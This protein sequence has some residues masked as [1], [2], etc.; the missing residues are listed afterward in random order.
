[1]S[2]R[3]LCTYRTLTGIRAIRRNNR[4]LQN[5]SLLHTCRP[6]PPRRRTYAV[7]FFNLL[8]VQLHVNLFVMFFKRFSLFLTEFVNRVFPYVIYLECFIGSSVEQ[9]QND[10]IIRL[11]FYARLLEEFPSRIFNFDNYFH[12]KYALM[13]C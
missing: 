8:I 13:V 4:Y 12:T 7:S 1:M 10:C 5:L 11:A 9:A 3:L 2:S 6:W